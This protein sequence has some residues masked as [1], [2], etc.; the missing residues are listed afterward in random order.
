MKTLKDEVVIKAYNFTV[1][2]GL[3]LSIIPNFICTQIRTYFF[4]P[5]SGFGCI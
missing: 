2:E 4:H 5:A 3:S 1:Y